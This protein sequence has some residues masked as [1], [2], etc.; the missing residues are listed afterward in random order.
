[1][2]VYFKGVVRA[3]GGECQVLIKDKETG[4]Y[5]RLAAGDMWPEHNLRILKIT[6]QSVLLENEKG[7][8]FLMRD[9]DKPPAEDDN[10][11]GGGRR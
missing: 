4:E 10:A 7:E 1:M 8:R 2:P 3:Q 6:M 11:P 5:R 9:V